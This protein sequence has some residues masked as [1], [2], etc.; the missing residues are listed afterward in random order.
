MRLTR[1][2][3]QAAPPPKRS[4]AS[5]TDSKGAEVSISALQPPTPLPRAAGGGEHSASELMGNGRRNG[6]WQTWGVGGSWRVEW[7]VVPGA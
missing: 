6:V 1:P 3:L 7:L 5:R 2:A 4:T